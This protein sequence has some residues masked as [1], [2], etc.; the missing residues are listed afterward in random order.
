LDESETYFLILEFF[1]LSRIEREALKQAYFLYVS[2]L[3]SV[4][5]MI[6]SYIAAFSV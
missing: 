6:G 4:L 1:L 2:L 5:K 3:F